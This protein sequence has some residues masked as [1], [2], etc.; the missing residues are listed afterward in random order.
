MIWNKKNPT[1]LISLYCLWN[2]C[3]WML[4]SQSAIDTDSV[5]SDSI[6]A[7]SAGFAKTDEVGQVIS[8]SFEITTCLI[9]LEKGNYVLSLH[10]FYNSMFHTCF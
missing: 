10:M 5:P 9:L 6:W 2:C 3:K 1:P 7:K 4:L 8:S